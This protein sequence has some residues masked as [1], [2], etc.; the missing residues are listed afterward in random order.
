MEYM[1]WFSLDPNY[2]NS[3]PSS[4]YHVTVGSLFIFS[5]STSLL[6]QTKSA[7]TGKSRDSCG[8][9]DSDKRIAPYSYAMSR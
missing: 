2:Y 5:S 3:G 6:S 9:H 8:A 7:S 1:N 4:S